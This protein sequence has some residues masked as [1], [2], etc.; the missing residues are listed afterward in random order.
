MIPLEI[1]G[2]LYVTYLDGACCDE[3]ISVLDDNFPYQ[4]IQQATGWG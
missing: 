4:M 1:L 2:L 3:Q